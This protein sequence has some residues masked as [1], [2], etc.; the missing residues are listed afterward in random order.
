MRT[1]KYT[2]IS[3][4]AIFLFG[5]AIHAATGP[6]RDKAKSG[7]YQAEYTTRQTADGRYEVTA[8]P[9]FRRIYVKLGG[10]LRSLYLNDSGSFQ[11][12]PAHASAD[13]RNAIERNLGDRLIVADDLSKLKI[14]FIGT[15]G[16]K[17]DLAMGGKYSKPI[18]RPGSGTPVLVDNVPQP[19]GIGSTS[20]SGGDSTP[21]CK[22]TGK[23]GGGPS[24]S[25]SSSS[26][27]GISSNSTSSSGSSSGSSTPFPI[28][29]LFAGT[30]WKQGAG[31]TIYVSPSGGGNG[32]SISSP[33]SVSA[34]LQRVAP[35]NTIQFA[36]G[37]Y[38]GFAIPKSGTAS[39]PIFFK[40][41]NPAVT[42]NNVRT[43]AVS[44]V[45]DSQASF[46]GSISTGKSPQHY[47]VVDGFRT[48][49]SGGGLININ[50]GSSHILTRRF[51]LNEPCLGTANNI[52]GAQ[53]IGFIG[54]YLTSMASSDSCP[55]SSKRKGGNRL[56]YGIV[57]FGSEEVEIRGNVFKGATNH[58][59]ST[60]EDIFGGVYYISNYFEG[61]GNVCLHVG[62]NTDYSDYGD[63]DATSKNAV[64]KNNV[65]VHKR[66][67][68]KDLSTGI[69]LQNFEHITVENNTFSGFSTPIRVDYLSGNERYIKKAS[70]WRLQHKGV[71]PKDILIKENSINGGTILLQSRGTTDDIYT[72]QNNTGSASCRRTKI[73]NPAKYFPDPF[74]GI[75]YNI[76]PKVSQS[77]N[78]FTCN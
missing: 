51:H 9:G 52:K 24:S 66:Y 45:P 67:P 72:L 15:D 26:S 31:P 3:A 63:G 64:I 61:C 19:G 7:L 48:K 37:I 12:A 69:S 71:T 74:P 1:L 27:G 30:V 34:A 42:V 16:K 68:T 70:P 23:C 5:G 4:V 10:V 33:T 77:G 50:K 22:L 62:Q 6:V 25:S 17:Y 32:N 59:D 44:L 65:F 55:A 41:Q 39:A 28:E 35:G 76:L 11:L 29:G 53:Y 38:P 36:P 43:G 60:K 18:P 49:H 2:F 14:T 47:I 20:S 73:W 78:S 57:N 46:I 13:Y 56:G 54:G 21:L 8:K 40:A 75:N 58:F